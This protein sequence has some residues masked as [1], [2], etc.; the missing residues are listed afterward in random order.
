LLE[1]AAARGGILA[2]TR[3]LGTHPVKAAATLVDGV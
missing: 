2:L 3:I 1:A